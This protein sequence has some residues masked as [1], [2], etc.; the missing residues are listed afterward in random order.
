MPQKPFS[1]A[2][3]RVAADALYGR[4]QWQPALARDL[5]IPPTTI[6]RWFS[7]RPLP[8]LRQLL[9][10]LCRKNAPENPELTKLARELD[11]LGPPER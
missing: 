8:D 3:L 4:T 2:D 7:G 5:R 10:D 6:K 1:L 11:K 9:A